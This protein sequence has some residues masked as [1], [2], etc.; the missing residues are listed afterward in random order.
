MA[1]GAVSEF[2]RGGRLRKIVIWAMAAL[3]NLRG[4]L[5]MW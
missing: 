4:A 1:V 5:R 2:G 3:R